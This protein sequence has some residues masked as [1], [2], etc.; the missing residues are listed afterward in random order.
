[1]TDQ[2]ARRF[3]D[4]LLDSPNGKGRRIDMLLL[5]M[6]I[7][8]MQRS[9]VVLDYR[10]RFFSND[11]DNPFEWLPKYP[12]IYANRPVLDFVTEMETVLWETVKHAWDVKHDEDGDVAGG[13]WN[14]NYVETA[15]RRRLHTARDRYFKMAENYGQAEVLGQQH[16]DLEDR[17][18]ADELDSAEDHA[19]VQRALSVL[20]S[21]EAIVLRM[22]AVHDWTFAEIG[23]ELRIDKSTAKRIFDKAREKAR[24]AIQ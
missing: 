12:E 22:R 13:M 18:Q 5:K 10:G 15:V 8:F 20:S 21:R 17:D 7:P 2:N 23:R 4:W 9:G 6:F 11:L 16:E 19:D 1:M 3:Q 14:W 24:E